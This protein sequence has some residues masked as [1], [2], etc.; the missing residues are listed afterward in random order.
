MAI[1]IDARPAVMGNKFVVTGSYA[2]AD[3]DID[4]SALL[5]TIDAVILNP[6]GAVAGAAELHSINDA[7][8]VAAGP[9][10]AAAGTFW[11]IGSR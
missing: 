3:S 5:S 6:S 10:W 9:G 4:L 8:I 7:T 11:A 2:A 1:T